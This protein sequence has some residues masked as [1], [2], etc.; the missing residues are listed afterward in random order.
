MLLFDAGGLR[1]CVMSV[2]GID[3]Q[4][5]GREARAL[6]LIG[7]VY[8]AAAVAI[9]KQ[10]AEFQQ[11]AVVAREQVQVLAPPCGR[12]SRRVA[13]FLNGTAAGLSLGWHRVRS[14]DSLF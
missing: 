9:S 13:S 8:W 5:P 2:G 3:D 10:R 6:D 12:R 1:A 14:P 11:Q 4:Q 7:G